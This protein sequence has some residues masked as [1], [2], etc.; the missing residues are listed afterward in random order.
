MRERRKEGRK[1][2]SRYFVVVVLCAQLCPTPCDPVDCSPP[3]SSVHGVLQARVLEGLAIPFCRG[4]SQ[5]W[6]R[7][8]V[9]CVS[10]IGRWALYLCAT[11]EA[12]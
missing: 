1:L 11:W 7:T 12:L 4:S 8:R 2:T 3:G 6:G 9:S 10:C 5:P